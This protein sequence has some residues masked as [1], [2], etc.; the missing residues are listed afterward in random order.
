M[1]VIMIHI[2]RIII[3][4]SWIETIDWIGVINESELFKLAIDLLGNELSL[5]M[6][7]YDERDHEIYTRK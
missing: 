3:S 6:Y 7:K 2:V 1:T 5:H 4:Y